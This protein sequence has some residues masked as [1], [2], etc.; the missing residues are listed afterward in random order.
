M[1][2]ILKMLIDTGTLDLG[3]QDDR[4]IK[5]RVEIVVEAYIPTRKYLITSTGEIELLSLELTIDDL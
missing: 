2:S 5:R 3:D 4:I 1:R